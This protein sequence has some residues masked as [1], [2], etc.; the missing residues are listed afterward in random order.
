MQSNDILHLTAFLNAL[1]QLDKPLPPNIQTRLN[2]I[3][4]TLKTDPTTIN[5]DIIAEDYPPLDETYQTEVTK[6]KQNAGERNKGLPPLPLPQETNTEI[7][8]SAIN[9]FSA[10][11]SVAAAK[12]QPN[13]LQKIWQKIK[14]P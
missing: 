3:A 2:Q 12:T 9:T 8:N 14:T 11:D 7:I 10:L 1:P 5:I 13:L 6:L 4:E